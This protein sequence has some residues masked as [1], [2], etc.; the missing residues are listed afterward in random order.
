MFRT[1]DGRPIARISETSKG[2]SIELFDDHR[3]VGLRMQATHPTPT[4]L[5]ENPYTVEERDPW[6]T[7][8][9]EHP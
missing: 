9:A 3:D 8:A 5:R 2:G 4:L 6:T 1:L 7:N